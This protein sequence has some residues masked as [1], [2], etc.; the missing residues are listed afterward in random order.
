MLTQTISILLVLLLISRTQSVRKA[1]ALGCIFL[2]LLLIP[3]D[4]LAQVQREVLLANPK[5]Y[6]LKPGESKPAAARCID[7][8]FEYPQTDSRYHSVLYGATEI[9]VFVGTTEMTLSEALQQ[10]KLEIK[11][12]GKEFYEGT[13]YAPA[14]GIP[15]NLINL[16]DET[17][18]VVVRK[19]VALSAE[20]WLEQDEARAFGPEAWEAVK[21]VIASRSGYPSNNQVWQQTDGL[22]FCRE[23]RASGVTAGAA[24]AMVGADWKRRTR[25]DARTQ[26]R[27]F[28]SYTAPAPS[29]KPG[30]AS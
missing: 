27:E 6:T 17:L 4:V 3:A 9:S 22:L 8:N 13:E 10:H 26:S 11:G 21:D 1:C 5:G 2:G 18:R 28:S 25:R 15:L 7:S 20:P 12:L 24:R 30:L 14:L 29:G 19:P 23:L 16:T